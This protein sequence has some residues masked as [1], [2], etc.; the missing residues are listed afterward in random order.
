MDEN[1]GK[2][3][4]REEQEQYNKKTARKT[5]LAIRFFRIL[6]DNPDVVLLLLVVFSA[7]CAGYFFA[8]FYVGLSLTEMKIGV[9]EFFEFL[10]AFII[11][12]SAFIGKLYT[13]QGIIS[14]TLSGRM[15]KESTL[16]GRSII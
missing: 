10:F 4:S 16:D 12:V 15:E 3:M 6:R 1:Q 8:R 13:K 2:K 9:A 14:K 7:V 11:T 5:G